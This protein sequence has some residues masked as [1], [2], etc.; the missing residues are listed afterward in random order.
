MVQTLILAGANFV[1]NLFLL[2]F[3]AEIFHFWYFGSEIFVIIIIAI[4][5]YFI[6]KNYIF[7]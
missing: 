4:N 5:N 6:Y 1:L 7:K 2:Y 3:F